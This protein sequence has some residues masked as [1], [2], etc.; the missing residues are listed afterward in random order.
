M[1]SDAESGEED[2]ESDTGSNEDSVMDV[3][4]LNF[5]THILDKIFDKK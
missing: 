5:P 2:S 4:N 3:E 1:S